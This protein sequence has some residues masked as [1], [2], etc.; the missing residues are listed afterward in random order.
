MRSEAEARL[1]EGLSFK[2][3][4][5]TRRD[6]SHDTNA[7]AER[8]ARVI[9]LR[10]LDMAYNLDTPVPTLEQAEARQFTDVEL[11][12]IQSQRPRLIFG[13]AA[14]CK[15]RLEALAAQYSADELMVL[16]ITGDYAT[17]ERSYELLAREF[18]LDQH[19]RE[20]IR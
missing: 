1:L 10:R 6:R 11:Q 3:V 14:T 5:S 20:P 16:T 2:L 18:A 19:G 7:E 15:S 12:H 13:D 9:D 8:M 17:R 4:Q